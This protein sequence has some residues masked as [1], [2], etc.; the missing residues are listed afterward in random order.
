MPEAPIKI[1][2]RL[3]KRFSLCLCVSVVNLFLLISCTAERRKSDAELGL[4][5]QQSAGR[6]IYDD[7][8]A[9]CHE[10]YSSSGKQGPSLEGIF[11]KPYFE[12]SGLPAND[13]RATDVIRFGR[14]KMTG[15]GQVLSQQQINDLLAYLHTL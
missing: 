3:T 2:R 9:R 10:P 4:T 11:K 15:F 12:M 5:P 6:R 13:A 8:C 1:R 7:N 14:D